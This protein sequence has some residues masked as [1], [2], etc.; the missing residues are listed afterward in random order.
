MIP[1]DN[2]AMELRTE[3]FFMKKK[4]LR[5][6]LA[7]CGLALLLFLVG[8]LTIPPRLQKKVSQE[9]LDTL[10][11]P[12]KAAGSG[13]DRVLCID[14]N[15]E[16]LLWRLRTMEA[17]S[18]ELILSAYG[19][20]EDDS[21]L[22]VMA[23]LLHTAERGVRVRILVDGLSEFLDLRSSK[24]F[25]ALA[26]SP[27]VEVRI[28][29]PVSLL[30]PWRLNYRM[31]DKYLAA[32]D[33]VYILGGR[34]IKN[35]SLGDYQ[36][37][38][39]HDRDVLVYGTEPNAQNSIHQVKDYFESVWSL[40][41]TEPFPAPETPDEAQLELLRQRRRALEET[42][43]ELLSQPDWEAI[44]L[45]THGITLLTNPIQAGNKAPELWATLMRLMA[46]SDAAVVQTPY[47]I[48][49]KVMYQDLAALTAAGKE[50]SIITNAVESG[51]NPWGC[52]DYMNQ[53]QKIRQ[54]GAHLYEYLGGHSAHRKTVL[55]DD[56]LSLVG[57][58]NFDMRSAYL[59][60]ELMLLIDSPELNQHLR[61]MAQ[62]NMAQSRHVFPDGSEV[63]G[64]AFQ[65]REMPWSKQLT[66][67]LIR[68]L[69]LPFRPL[70]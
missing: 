1:F 6:V 63:P 49:N 46:E 31:H 30:K 61:S 67:G 36:E 3:E 62:D 28:Y 54:T 41:T 27:Q 14:D 5:R 2:E 60:T 66:Y 47:L 19:M 59:D 43:P 13:A 55:I 64:E 24:P 58:F 22:D 57:S 23:S 51:A 56:H 40:E 10:A 7:G 32:D 38:K 20:N 21:G 53:K 70:L 69:I 15:Q 9:F 16:A 33:T 12:P 34:N 44:T 45:P 8:S 48:C 29:N 68:L 11:L 39:D 4:R 37:K 18:Q 35:L 17:A 52:A 25:Q 65:P 26:A 42:W 50:I